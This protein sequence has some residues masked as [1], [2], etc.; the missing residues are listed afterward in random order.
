MKKPLW[1]HP[2]LESAHAREASIDS[3]VNEDILL[4]FL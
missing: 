3:I 1:H 2:H 4:S